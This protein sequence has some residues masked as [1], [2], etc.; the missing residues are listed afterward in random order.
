LIDGEA[1]EASVAAL[2]RDS[3]RLRIGNL[4][5]K[6]EYTEYARTQDYSNARMR[7]LRTISPEAN[8]QMQTLTPTPHP[9]AKTIDR[10][11][12]GPP[13]GKGAVGRSMQ[14]QV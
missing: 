9:N 2:N 10:W 11:T 14:E 13:L 6:F 5:Y 4:D 7:F 3:A 8:I 12:L 1:I